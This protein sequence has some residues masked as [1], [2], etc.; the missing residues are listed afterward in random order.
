MRTW[1]RFLMFG[2]LGAAV[3]GM[4]GCGGSG[5]P[6]DAGQE[7]GASGGGSQELTVAIWDTY[8]E[9]GLKEIMAGFTE[10]TGKF[11]SRA[12]I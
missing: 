2:V 8:Q 11:C 7:G 12:C 6:A 4:A 5:G 9:P 3:L 1:G 10:E